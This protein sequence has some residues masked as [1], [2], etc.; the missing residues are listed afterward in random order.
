[1]PFIHGKAYKLILGLTI[2]VLLVGVSFTQR[3]LNHDRETLGLTRLDPLENA[4]PVL[5]FT[6]VALGGFRGLIAN[7]LWVRASE[8]QENDRYFEMVQLADWITKL[9]PHFTTVWVHQAWNMSY[10]ISVKFT[11]PSD[12]W[13][14]VRRG[15]EILRDEGLKYN[16]KEPLIYRELAWHFQHKMGANLDD[17]HNYYKYVWAEEM[18]DLLGSGHPDFASL[19]NPETEEQKERVR[20]LREHYKLDPRWMKEVDDRYGPLEWRLPETHA[21]YW[22]VVGLEM[23]KGDQRKAEDLMQLRRVIFQSM[24]LAFHRGRLIFPD[25]EGREFIYGPNLEIVEQV[26]RSYEEMMDAEPDKRDHIGTGHRNF[27]RTAVYFLYTHN[28][29]N[30]AEEWFQILKDKYPHERHPDV[31][32]EDLSLDD[33]ALARVEEDIGETSHD[34]VKTILLGLFF[35]SYL[36]LAMGDYDQAAGYNLFAQRVYNRFQESIGDISME[37]VGLGELE[38]LRNEV[39]NEMLDPELGLQPVYANRLRTELGLPVSGGISMQQTDEPV[40]RPNSAP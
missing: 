1:M 13:Q 32:P 15:I 39:L 17:A 38:H 16:P 12:R 23:S 30:A 33:Y 19:M 11:E 34:R 4:P 21:I 7:I 9:Q 2:V 8:L 29:M 3:Q 25:R 6:T 20:I 27:L 31:P 22:A 14:W 24:Q 5:A 36:S 35:N 10:N 37:R 26:S 40:E 18:N 28:R